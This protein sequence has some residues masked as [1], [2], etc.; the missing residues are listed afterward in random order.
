MCLYSTDPYSIA[1]T[2]V[3]GIAH[4]VV[5][6]HK[7]LSRFPS[8]QA[9][10]LLEANRFGSSWKAAEYMPFYWDRA[11]GRAIAFIKGD[12]LFISSQEYY[13]RIQNE[14]KQEIQNIQNKF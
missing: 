2:F 13:Q 1:I 5:Y 6:E 8:D 3:Y 11:D 4:Q 14:K 9:D 7:T 10:V 12:K